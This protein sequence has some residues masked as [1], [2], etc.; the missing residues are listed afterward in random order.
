MTVPA[1]ESM[2]WL[3]ALDKRVAAVTTE[4]ADLRKKNRSLVAKVNRLERKARERSEAESEGWAS[5]KA[6]LK[7]RVDGLAE[8][9]ELLLED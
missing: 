8:N 7:E 9:L 5:Q 6:E 2:D 4:V 3:K 1:D